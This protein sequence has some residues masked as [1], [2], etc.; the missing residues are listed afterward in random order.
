MEDRTITIRTSDGNSTDRPVTGGVPQ[1]SVLGPTLW[2]VFYDDI[3]RMDVP[4]GVQLVGFADDLALLAVGE[5]S[6]TLEEVV[7][8]TLDAIDGW[9]GA[10]GLQ[11]ARHKTEAT[12]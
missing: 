10:H 1:G 11:L 7:N 6:D 3:L 4:E 12:C 5:T 9:M 8:T 2:N